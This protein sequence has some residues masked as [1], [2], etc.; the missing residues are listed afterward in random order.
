M[1]FSSSPVGA[2][3]KSACLLRS[4]RTVAVHAA[5]RGV[6]AFAARGARAASGPRGAE[7]D[8][9][10]VRGGAVVLKAYSYRRSLTV[11][12]SLR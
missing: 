11:S 3:V 1:A 6:W 12:V 8:T 7:S 10:R 2:L 9:F 4:V 5:W